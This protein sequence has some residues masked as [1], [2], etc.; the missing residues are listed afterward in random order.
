M[1]GYSR[2][3]RP[4]GWVLRAQ[5]LSGVAITC[6]AASP[7][8]AQLEEIEVTATKTGATL[9]QKTPIAVTAFTSAEIERSLINNVKDLVQFT[10]NLTVPQNNTFA[11]I[12]IR[13][14]GSNNVFN[15]S[16]PSSTVHVD[17]V[18]QARPYAQFANFLDVERVEVLRGPQGT[19]YGRNSV[20]G[21][22][23]VISR[24]PTDE[25]RVKGDLTVGNY[26]TV[27]EQAYLSGALIPGKVQASISETYSR[28]D[29]YRENIVASG[30]DIDSQNTG[31]VRVQVRVQPTASIEA[32]T[33]VDFASAYFNPMGYAKILQPFDAA[34]NSILGDYSKVALNQPGLGTVRGYGFAEDV[35]ADVGN[36]M[37]LRSVTAYRRNVVK[38][39]TDTDSTDRDT[40]VTL[41]S[42]KEW[43]F[44]EEL[45]LSGK[46]GALDY[47]T[48]LYYFVEHIG[49]LTL[50]NQRA[51]GTFTGVFPSSHTTSKA[52]YAQGTYH[53]TDQLSVTAGARYSEE[54]KLFYGNVGTYTAATGALRGAQT[55]YVGDGRYHAFTPKAGIEYQLTPDALLFV[56]AT[57]GFK[58]G[59]FNQTSTTSAAAAGFAPESLWSYEAGLKSEWFNRRLRANLTAFHYD[60]SN[61]QV[62]AFIRPGVTD[63][64]NA[65]DATINGVE[66]ELRT[67]P[68]QNLELGANLASLDATY[69]K[70]PGA[71]GPGGVVIDATGKRLNA[72]PQYSAN[73]SAQYDVPLSSGALVSLRGEYFWQ[74]KQFFVASNDPAQSQGAYGLFNASVAYETEDGHWRVALWG[75]NLF[76]RQYITAT[77]TISPVV[78]GRPGDPR[79]F[80][81][82]LTW[83]M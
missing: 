46:L 60:Y 9:L 59:G 4:A 58:S 32:T 61:L 80:G 21:T 33:R 49:T 25:L 6:L 5:L 42:E 69:G 35:A 73:L 57:R 3:R 30:N 70:Y 2:A 76:D 44:S 20:G 71:S 50:V 37:K 10:P 40:T 53:L 83:K 34:T 55:L 75:K 67:R 31:S 62:Q 13:G 18:Y 47:V 43:Q 8:M 39:L 56:S 78:S 72:S 81:A 16:D 17:G 24:A 14:I 52:A 28:H 74:D 51:A 82:R 29:P 15:G 79:T 41:T 38:T 23:N 26:G 65:A 36:G 64:T 66:L 19:L 77:A 12:Y 68:L 45:N 63:I 1:A 27:Q 7:A 48:G 54:E 22:I 11:Q